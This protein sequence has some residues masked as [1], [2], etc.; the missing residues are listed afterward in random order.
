MLHFY[1]H[2]NYEAEV[3]P[4]TVARE[5]AYVQSTKQKTAADIMAMA[6]FLTRGLSSPSSPERVLSLT[7]D[8]SEMKLY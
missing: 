3:K 7:G 6:S 2:S 1:V 5:V 8:H 4:R